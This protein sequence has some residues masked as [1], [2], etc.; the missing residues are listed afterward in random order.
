[1]NFTN[2]NR[3]LFIS[4]AAFLLAA[5]F[6]LAGV[7]ESEILFGGALAALA[8]LIAVTAKKDK[9]MKKTMMKKAKMGGALAAVMMG[10]AVFAG[11]PAQVEDLSGE[12]EAEKNKNKE[13]QETINNTPNA[14]EIIKVLDWANMPERKEKEQTGPD[15]FSPE[16]SLTFHTRNIFVTEAL[17]YFKLYPS[18]NSDSIIEQTKQKL[19]NTRSSIIS[20][21]AKHNKIH[22][23]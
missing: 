1:M 21:L 8:V 22:S 2:C 23:V 9:K 6:T 14:T 5:F 11:C 7:I 16:I 17:E 13:L 12:L 15:T 3:G 20:K 4:F 18:D 19:Y 10:S